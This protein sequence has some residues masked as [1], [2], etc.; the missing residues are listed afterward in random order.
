MDHVVCSPRRWAPREQSASLLR[1]GTRDRA[2]LGHETNVH[3]HTWLPGQSFR[4]TWVLSSS[5]L[6]KGQHLLVCPL[7]LLR[8]LLQEQKLAV[9]IKRRKPYLKT[10]GHVNKTMPTEE[11]SS[12]CPP[13]LGLLARVRSSKC[14][15]FILWGACLTWIVRKLSSQAVPRAF[16]P[17]EVWGVQCSFLSWEDM[18]AQMSYYS[19]RLSL[20]L[21]TCPR[22]RATGED[23]HGQVAPRT[24]AWGKRQTGEAAVCEMLIL[25]SCKISHENR[26]WPWEH[27]EKG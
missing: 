15:L 22:E 12:H 13:R 9:R 11:V 5:L 27:N 20:A 19:V 21:K 8:M 3:F 16:K 2:V 23:S 6:E 10:L 7:F 17:W 18:K 24:A 4:G 1:L 14:W 25:D 26:S